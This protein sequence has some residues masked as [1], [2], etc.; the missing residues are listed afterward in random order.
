[1]TKNKRKDE[2]MPLWLALAIVF[3]GV[4]AIKAIILELVKV[5]SI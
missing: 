3:I 2:R 5:W 4:I 1:M